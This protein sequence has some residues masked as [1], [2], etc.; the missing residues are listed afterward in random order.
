MP[1][2]RQELEL[3][4]EAVLALDQAVSRQ[5]LQVGPETGRH[6]KGHMHHCGCPEEGHTHTHTHTLTRVHPSSPHPL[7]PSHLLWMVT[8]SW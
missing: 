4:G 5:Q 1:P 2:P 8:E 6:H 7:T 3:R